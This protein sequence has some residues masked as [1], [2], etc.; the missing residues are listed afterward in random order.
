MSSGAPFYRTGVIIAI[1][2]TIAQ[3]LPIRIIPPYPPFPLCLSRRD[4]AFG[5]SDSNAESRGSPMRRM[6]RKQPYL[7]A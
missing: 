7:R 2:V 3:G 4:L 6:Q 1:D 5:D